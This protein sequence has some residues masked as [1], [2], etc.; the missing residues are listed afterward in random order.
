ML[1]ESAS[2]EL[3]WPEIEYMDLN[4]DQQKAANHILEGNNVFLTGSAGTGN[5]LFIYNIYIIYMQYI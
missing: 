2:K 3:K 1:S 4:E 5:S